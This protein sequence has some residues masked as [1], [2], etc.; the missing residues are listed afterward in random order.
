M[1]LSRVHDASS[2][3][4]RSSTIIMRFFGKRAC[5]FARLSV[6]K[7][8]RHSISPPSSWTL[9][10]NPMKL[11]PFRPL[12]ATRLRSTD[13]IFSAVIPTG[14]MMLSIWR[15]SLASI[16]ASSDTISLL[17]LAFAPPSAALPVSFNLATIVSRLA[18]A[19]S[20]LGNA[21][22]SPCTVPPTLTCRAISP[23]KAP[24]P[25]PSGPPPLN[26]AFLLALAAAGLILITVPATLSS[27][28]R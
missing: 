18:E 24:F 2:T 6:I 9:L 23:P 4:C 21:F 28:R 25:P 7:A 27:S 17:T 16:S 20:D 13:L 12:R 1:C 26:D 5:A 3:H 15:S 8:E 11:E 14:S 10:S 19:G 22:D